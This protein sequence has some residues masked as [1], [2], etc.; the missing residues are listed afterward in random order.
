MSNFEFKQVDDT[1][2]WE[3]DF[4]RLEFSNPSVQGFSDFTNLTDEKEILYYYYTV[5]IFKK[6]ADWDEEDNDVSEWEL[7]S[8][9]FTHDFPMIRQLKWLLEYQLKD[10]PVVDGQKIKYTN[11]NVR[12]AKVMETD[13]FACDDF[14]EI[15]KSVDASGGDERYIVYCGTTFDFQSDL[16]STGLRT[17]YVKRS[18]IEELLTCV[19]SFIGYSLEEH[20]KEAQL[21]ASC[22]EVKNGKIY[23]YDILDENV[24]KT[25]IESIYAVGDRV[26][27][28]AVIDNKENEYEEAVIAQI[29]GD[30][31]VLKM[32]EVIQGSTIA[33]MSHEQTKEMLVY[34]QQDI[35]KEFMNVLSDE[36]TEELRQK[37]VDDLLEKYKMAIINRTAMCRSEHAFDI[38]YETGDNIKAVTPIVKEVI[39]IIKE[40]L[41]DGKQN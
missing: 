6:I 19:T 29:E 41:L 15:R 3:S 27:L 28:F 8:E 9:R 32:G 35:A 20:N 10:N 23:E 13:G 22:Y 16:N 2:R 25:T 11:G 4:L 31:V 12:Y 37:S 33:Y 38:D 34:K 5:K 26:H 7:V 36:E 30:R 17:P 1:F 14:Y 21:L 39:N 40:T 18:D 24:D